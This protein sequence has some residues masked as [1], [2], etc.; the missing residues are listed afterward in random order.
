MFER[1]HTQVEPAQRR[2][3]PMILRLL[4][5]RMVWVVLV[6]VLA[7]P[8]LIG[9]TTQVA[10]AQSAVPADVFMPSV[11]KGDGKL[12]WHQL[13]SPVQSQ[14]SLSTL[15]STVQQQRGAETKEGL[16]LTRDSL[17]ADARA[18]GG[19]SPLVLAAY[20]GSSGPLWRGYYSPTGRYTPTEQYYT[21]DGTTCPPT[22]QVYTNTAVETWKLVQCGPR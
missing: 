10:Q 7:L 15:V 12:G 19:Q 21:G 2:F 5:S 16:S 14:V 9:V 22:Y 11:V 17:G 20:G 1:N 3:H 4:S 8:T 13:G 18:Q 6:V